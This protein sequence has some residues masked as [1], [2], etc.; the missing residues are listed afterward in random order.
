MVSGNAMAHLYLD[1]GNRRAVRA[2]WSAL[3][4]KWAWLLERL[5]ER[6]S[7]DLL[8]IPLDDNSCEVRAKGRGAAR[9]EMKEGRYS[10]RPLTGDPLAIGAHESLT[11]DEAYDATVASDYPD[12]LVQI[13]HLA[14]SARCGE[15]MLS[16]SRNWDYRAKY[17]PIPH[18]SS[19]GALPQGTHAGS[20]RAQ[21]KSARLAAPNGRR[22]AER[23]RG[24]RTAGARRARRPKL[25]VIR[26]EA[27]RRAHAGGVDAQRDLRRG[28]AGRG[29]RRIASPHPT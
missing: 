12:A 11:H 19:H 15:I 8:F 1:L 28:R 23:A 5:L 2:P 25:L 29:A 7:V 21:S 17:E 24:A 20:A 13:A 27:S 14:G 16:A 3:E 18:V 22:D 26:R 10:Y 6:E 4:K 9:V